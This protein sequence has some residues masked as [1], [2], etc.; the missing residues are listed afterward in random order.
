M[1]TDTSSS[2][3]R[4]GY[5]QL[6]EQAG[7]S[8]RRRSH[9]LLHDSHLDPVQ[10]VLVALKRGTYIQPHIHSRQWEMIVPIEGALQTMFFSNDGVLRSAVEISSNTTPLLQVPAGVWHSIIPISETAVMME[11]KPGPFRLAE[12]AEWSPA[13]GHSEDAAHFSDWL[14]VARPGDR[15]QTPIS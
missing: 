6:L 14:M 3:S 11:V 13:E 15:W 2:V 5:K 9:L 8:T 7:Q 4:D 12:F 10:R 1:R